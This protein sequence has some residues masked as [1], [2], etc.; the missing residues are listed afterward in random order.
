PFE[1][2]VEELQPERDLAHS[3][4]VQVLLI[5]QNAP[6]GELQL[7]GLTL[8]RLPYEAGSAKFDL[9]LAFGETAGGL[10]GAAEYNRDLFDGATVARFA[11]HLQ[12][13]LAAAAADPARPVADLPLLSAAERQAVL[14]DWSDGGSL[15]KPSGEEG[16]LHGLVA[17]QAA[18]TPE[19]RALIWAPE[20]GPR[21][22]LTYAALMARAE[23]LARR[24]AALGVGPEVRVGV[25][26]ARTA[27]LPVALLAILAAGGAYVPLDP[28]Y[29]AA[30]LALMID[31]ARAG[32]D[33]FVLLT[34]SHLRER[35]AEMALAAGAALLCVDDLEGAAPEPA[36]PL[37]QPSPT[38]LAY[39]IY[40]SG[41]TGR[42]KGVAIEHRSAAAFCRWAREWFSDAELAGVFASTS[43]N[44][45]LSV[46]ELFVP[47]AWGGTV[48]LGDN[49][50][51]LATTPAAAEVTLINTVPSAMTE[52]VR[53]GAVPPSVRTVNLAGEPV[54]NALAQRI[55][56]LGTVER[57]WN[58]YGPSEDTTY[59]TFALAAP[60]AE[61]EPT[62]GRAVAG[63]RAYVLDRRLNPCPPGV[64]GELFLGGEGLARGYL[65]RPELTAERFVPDPFA[66]EPGA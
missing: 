1:K 12:T 24:L 8:S 29:P 23:R 17:A 7:P 40:T 64:P 60:G 43:I 59:S 21:V 42:P 37:T 52:L 54:R 25:A 19:R 46:Y 15:Q 5:L 41:S 14:A 66:A 57:V 11:G 47:L 38:N 6:E 53:L 32:Q 50:L 33:G 28:S 3:P 30:R 62:I 44:F 61:S 18:R 51:A 13:L 65:H 55:H 4:L 56:A 10:A 26:L 2:L 20:E 48:I 22:E 31:D 49:A 34:Q 63:S 16:L 9:T 36:A 35:L 45:D 58:L 27:D 39:L